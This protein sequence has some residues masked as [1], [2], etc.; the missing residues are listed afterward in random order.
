ME[1]SVVFTAFKISL[2]L[3]LPVTEH[4]LFL[5]NGPHTET[6]VAVTVAHIPVVQIEVEAPRAVRVANVE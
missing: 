4:G 3:S 2:C 5:P 6:I 1:I